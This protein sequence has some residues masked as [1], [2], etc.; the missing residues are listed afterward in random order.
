MT[1]I[2]NI[3]IYFIMGIKKMAFQEGVS[4]GAIFILLD[5]GTHPLH[6]VKGLIALKPST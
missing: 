5:E 4:S 6:R 3:A 2:D 1:P